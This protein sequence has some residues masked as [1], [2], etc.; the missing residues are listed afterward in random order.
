MVLSAQYSCIH[1]TVNGHHAR[2]I[3]C[4]LSSRGAVTDLADIEDCPRLSDLRIGGIFASVSALL[5]NLQCCNGSRAPLWHLS[6]SG[7]CEEDDG[8]ESTDFRSEKSE[9]A[10]Y[11]VSYIERVGR[12]VVRCRNRVHAMLPA[13]TASAPGRDSDIWDFPSSNYLVM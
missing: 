13:R 5:Y 10:A 9:S 11:S 7:P 6:K 3:A 1:G 8:A 4:C 12:T 2:E